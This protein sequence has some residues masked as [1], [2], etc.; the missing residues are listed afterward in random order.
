MWS[1]DDVPSLP[2]SVDV[3]DDA[4]LDDPDG[5]MSADEEPMAVTRGEMWARFFRGNCIRYAKQTT[6][7][8]AARGPEDVLLLDVLTEA[9]VRWCGP[10]NQLGPSCVTLVLEEEPAGL[11]LVKYRDLAT[12]THTPVLLLWGPPPPFSGRYA[13]LFSAED[14]TPCDCRFGAHR[15]GVALELQPGQR[16]LRPLDDTVWF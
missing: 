8:T 3:D 1:D 10:R 12:T 5:W 2:S 9:L 16:V 14:G 11:Q 13:T 15:S 7:D 6:S 4:M